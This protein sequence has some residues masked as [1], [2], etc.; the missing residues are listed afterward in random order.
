[1]S[2]TLFAGFTILP[3]TAS[4]TGT[5]SYRSTSAASSISGSNPTPIKFRPPWQ[6]RSTSP[7]RRF[8]FVQAAG[9]RPLPDAKHRGQSGLRRSKRPAP[10]S[11]RQVARSRAGEQHILTSNLSVACRR[12]AGELE[13]LPSIPRRLPKSS[14]TAPINTRSAAVQIDSACVPLVVVN[15][16]TRPATDL[17]VYSLGEFPKSNPA[18]GKPP[19]SPPNNADVAGLLTTLVRLDSEFAATTGSRPRTTSAA[20]NR[21]CPT[22]AHGTTSFAPAASA[23]VIVVECAARRSPPPRRPPFVRPSLKREGSER[24]VCCTC[25]AA[26]KFGIVDDTGF[27]AC[28]KWRFAGYSSVAVRLLC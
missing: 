1:M 14:Q 22:S 3:T 8:H 5:K 16:I 19:R 10:R 21:A 13:A 2:G 12:T 24:K 7:R 9:C 27:F 11:D 28:D 26:R 17:G 18:I 20:I 25:R 23:A 15:T 4:N 6:S